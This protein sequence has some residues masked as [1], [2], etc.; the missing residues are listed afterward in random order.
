ML[1]CSCPGIMWEP[2]Q[3]QAHTQL[4]REHSASHLFA[5]PLWPDPSIKK[6]NVS[7]IRVRVLISTSKHTKKST[8]WV[9]MVEHSQQN[10][11]QKNSQSRKSHLLFI[12]RLILIILHVLNETSPRQI[13]MHIVMSLANTFP[14]KYHCILLVSHALLLKY[15]SVATLPFDITWQHT[16]VSPSNPLALQQTAVQY[17]TQRNLLASSGTCLWML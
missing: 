14:N 12:T 2:I 6:K 10:Q 17:L 13:P 5:E 1:K 3:K 7:G 4:V 8:G 15:D 16:T 9:W 11:Q